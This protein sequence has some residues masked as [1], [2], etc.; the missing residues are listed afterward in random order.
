MYPASVIA[1]STFYIFMP[2]DIDIG[3]ESYR[4]TNHDHHTVLALR[5]YFVS[6]CSCSSS[7]RYLD[8][9]PEMRFWP[10]AAVSTGDVESMR[11]Y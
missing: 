10:V 2:N 1:L 4:V 3:D 6:D 5:S 9:S 8:D 7:S 11:S